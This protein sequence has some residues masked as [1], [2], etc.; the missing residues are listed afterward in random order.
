MS[1]SDLLTDDQLK[2]LLDDYL[3]GYLAGEYAH[4]DWPHQLQDIVQQAQRDLLSTDELDSLSDDALVERLVELYRAI[5][6]VP[7]YYKAFST[8]V[9]LCRTTLRYLLESDESASAKVDALLGPEGRFRGTGLGKSFW[10]VLLMALD[11]ALNPPWTN[12][13]E[14]VLKLLGMARWVRSDTPGQ[15][16]SHIAE[17]QRMLISL[18]PRADLYTIDQFM[19]YVAILEGKVKIERW[20]NPPAG[21]DDKAT[22]GVRYWKIAPG[23]GAWNWEACRDGGFIAIGW[24]ELGDLSGLN[25]GDFE[26]RRDELVAKHDDWTSAGTNQG[27]TFSHVI[28]KGDRIVANRG[29]DQVLGIGT[30]TGPYYFVPGIRHGH[31]LPV[32]WDDLIARRVHKGGWRRT[33]VELDRGEFEGIASAPPIDGTP[34]AVLGRPFNQVF[35][36]VEEAEWAFDLLAET[37]QRL[38]IQ[39]PGDERFALTVAHRYG[40]LNL[41]LNF[42]NWLVLGFR[43]P[44]L[45]AERVRICLLSGL[46]DLGPSLVEHSFAQAEEEPRV[47]GYGLPIHLVRPL[48]GVM[49]E[50]YLAALDVAAVRFRSYTGCPYRKS[51]LS[52]IAEAVF[53]PEKRMKLLKG[54]LSEDSPTSEEPN[55]WW[56]NQGQT[57]D[58]ERAGGYLWAPTSSK[59]GRQLYHWDTLDEL[60]EDDMVLHYAHGRLGYVS[61]VTAPAVMAE[62]PHGIESNEWQ[63]A[64][65]LVR[66][67]YHDLRPPIALE[68]FSQ[69]LSRLDIPQ[70]P[71][72]SNGRPKQGYLFRLTPEALRLIEQ[73]QPDTVWPD[74]VEQPPGR[75]AGALNPVYTLAQ[76]AA[77]TG[78]EQAELTRWVRAIERKK[79]VILYGPPGTGK[80]YVA[81][82]LAKHLVGG[83][84]GFLDLVQFHPAYAYEDFIQGI[85]PRA[86]ADGQLDYPVVPGR[87]L[88]FC[89]QASGRQDRCVLIIDE[90]NRANLAR[91]FGE[92]M[93][94]LE[95]RDREV[96]LAAGGSLS[97]PANVRMIGTM[98][99]ADRSIALVD[100]AL[101]RRFAFLAL[102]PNYDLLRGFHEAT[103]FDP[104]PLIGVLRR[105]N[106]QIG[107]RH[108]EV[109]I[110]FFLREDLERDIEDVWRMEI[111]PYLEEYFFDQPDKVDDCRW[112]RVRGE[113]LP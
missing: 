5:V 12:K 77:E 64:G 38:G 65:R 36:D 61:R 47:V 67:D 63:E 11:P 91:V 48:E 35:V 79:Q 42:G 109:G 82:R 46:A 43:G 56:V 4:D 24:D 31:Q 106:T 40:G 72:D 99:T 74:F 18:D 102:Y 96:P 98:N 59:G 7:L 37:M 95:Y 52:E 76:C 87:F 54:G 44:N 25:K 29:K 84:D 16:Y 81:E 20:L 17:A 86:R 34:S 66:V 49:R 57:L 33:V 50:A 70:G 51:H 110:T 23:K 21:D 108:Y 3:T 94:L 111:E 68:T 69:R 22:G 104:E 9:D 53:D 32:R 105:L 97:I 19:H 14:K 27:W 41:H 1:A 75:V 78:F 71:L 26:A 112:D 28:Q 107:D 92:M 10:S 15:I 90:I 89:R 30:V 80:T 62:R 101:R 60:R 103:G 8:R 2:E 73:S 58:A 85:R 55:V 93:Y 113:I 100:H 83:G 13:T 6:A 88:D 45:Q 39:N